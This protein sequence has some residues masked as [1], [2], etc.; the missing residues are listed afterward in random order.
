MAHAVL[1]K[2]YST[3]KEAENDKKKSSYTT[4]AEAGSKRNKTPRGKQHKGG[5]RGK[6]GVA[7][8]TSAK[9][10]PK[11]PAAEARE[12]R[13]ARK[14][15]DREVKDAQRIW[16]MFKLALFAAFPKLQS[17][18][19]YCSSEAGLATIS[20]VEHVRKWI[21]TSIRKC[22]VDWTVK[23]VK[24]YCNYCRV[25]SVEDT[26]PEVHV[27][28]RTFPVKKFEK[29]WILGLINEKFRPVRATSLAQFARISRGLPLPSVNIV[30]KN[31]KQ[32][33]KDYGNFVPI[34]EEIL[35][36][37]RAWAESWSY[38]RK[39]FLA[40]DVTV[41]LRDSASATVTTARGGQ[42]Q[43]LVECAAPYLEKTFYENNFEAE[44][45]M[46]EVFGG[47][48]TGDNQEDMRCLIQCAFDRSAEALHHLGGNHVSWSAQESF[49]PEQTA[50]LDEYLTFK[51]TAVEELGGKARIVTTPPAYITV[52]GDAIRKTV[53]P[54]LAN[55]KRVDL[56]GKRT[57][58]A[59][60]IQTGKDLQDCV[61]HLADAGA[62]AVYYSADL[63]RAT[64]LMPHALASSLWEGLCDGLG[65]AEGEVL[66]APG[67]ALLG[68]VCIDYSKSTCPD[69][70]RVYSKAG[71]LMGCPLSWTILSL[72]NLACADMAA[73][74]HRNKVPLSVRNRLRGHVVVRGDDMAAAMPPSH[75]DRYEALISKTGGEANTSKSF[76]SDSAFI[77]AERTFILQFGGEAFPEDVRDYAVRG[78]TFTT[79]PKIR[80]LP[81]RSPKGR[82]E[83]ASRATKGDPTGIYMLKDVPLRHLVQKPGHGPPGWYN[84]GPA[85]AGALSEF[86]ESR[87]Y[88]ALCR[89]VLSCNQEAVRQLQAA[90]I[91]VFYPRELGG[92]GFPHPKGFK[93][94]LASAGRI[95]IKRASLAL[96]TFGTEARNRY[97]LGCGF[98]R[99]S[100][101]DE[102]RTQAA[103][104]IDYVQTTHKK[105]RTMGVLVPRWR[106][107]VITSEAA[108]GATW[109]RAFTDD[110]KSKF[111]V[112]SRWKV[113]KGWN[114][115]IK[116]IEKVRFPDKFLTKVPDLSTFL[117]RLEMVTR[118]ELCYWWPTWNNNP[119]SSQLTMN[120]LSDKGLVTHKEQPPQQTNENV[121]DAAARPDVFESIGVH[122]QLFSFPQIPL[123]CKAD[124]PRRWEVNPL[125]KS[126]AAKAIDQMSLEEY[127]K[128]TTS[129]GR[130][131]KER[132]V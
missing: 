127:V 98:W 125:P 25:R 105:L 34:E 118:A 108:F 41:S 4:P 92:G 91:P 131:G 38:H 23:A 123:P 48:S 72:Y 101:V 106:E 19:W 42:L 62:G 64:D 31:L 33:A 53:W 83:L 59:S 89:A 121:E 77:L 3:Q 26:R 27:P 110:I 119:L 63:T 50:I 46:F 15:M 30:V 39:K 14:L 45:G 126:E 116:A 58:S 94:A 114:N 8:P 97:K 104:Q 35:L 80:S 75:C 32:H 90:K 120:W 47:K 21:L 61:F 88:P 37:M 18:G 96:T 95:G 55:E 9:K 85:A 52:L 28:P 65:K 43:E 107:D 40:T 74:W 73:G 60:Q 2:E 56:S 132:P 67:R 51:A 78:Y 76:R 129:F 128:F 109:R 1:L 111:E 57:G 7:K 44:A 24:S 69:L 49:T 66:R 112:P 36:D 87:A 102:E 130:K 100:S 113:G 5:G 68:P 29:G 71:I 84:I 124:E 10:G 12:I 22:G 93:G 117:S 17:D 70:G 122:R 86:T 54:L 11:I 82:S 16:D 115:A 6:P 20:G 79:P 81:A 99:N 103:A 13:K